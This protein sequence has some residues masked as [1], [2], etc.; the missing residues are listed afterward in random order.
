VENLQQECTKLRRDIHDKLYEPDL[1]RYTCTI[2]AHDFPQ[3][4][5]YIKTRIKELRK[6]VS[7]VVEARREMANNLYGKGSLKE[8]EVAYMISD[9]WH[10][11]HIDERQDKIKKYYSMLKSMEFKETKKADG[12]VSIGTAE[13]NAAKQVPID[14]FIQFNR[15]LFAPCIWHSEKTPSM[16]YY[17]DKNKVYCFSCNKGGDVIDVVQHV[18]SISF[19]EA[20]KRLI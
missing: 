9:T 4:K 20:V 16:K 19:I 2:T 8:R 12:S 15:A 14:T 7:D 18:N 1:T 6:E 11:L 3:A 13:V 5:S 10:E 17:P